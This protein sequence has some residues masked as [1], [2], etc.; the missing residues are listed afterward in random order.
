MGRKIKNSGSLSVNGE[1]AYFYT[2]L[3]AGDSLVIEYHE[4]ESN[5]VEPSAGPLDILYEDAELFVVV[6]P[7]LLAVQ[8]SAKHPDNLVS[9]IK[10]HYKK[11][12]IRNMVHIVNRLDYATSG[13]MVIAKEGYMHYLLARGPLERK[14]LAVVS[15]IPKAEGKVELNIARDPNHSVKRMINPA[16]QPAR[17][18]YRLVKAE[19]KRSILEL[20]LITGRTHQI[21]LH[22]AAIGHP[23][24]GD[25]LYGASDG[26]LMLHSYY[27]SFSHP[28]TKE[29]MVFRHYPPW[30]KKSVE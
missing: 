21:R 14:Y 18:E 9:R 26:I 16:G 11:S 5:N 12:D 2:V 8:P 29:I 19:D 13:L 4:S 10:S 28:R 6:K 20:R 7:P 15:G 27:I 30:Y 17:T 1:P 3:A 24:I 23:V 22:M 25:A